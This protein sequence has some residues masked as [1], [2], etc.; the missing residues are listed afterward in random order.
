MSGGLSLFV[1]C[2]VH[3]GHEVGLQQN[4]ASNKAWAV[5]LAELLQ[6]FESQYP[7]CAKLGSSS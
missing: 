1:D 4:V 5:P 6:C 7:A 2:R 3:E